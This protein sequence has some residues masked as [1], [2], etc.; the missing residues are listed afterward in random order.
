MIRQLSELNLSKDASSSAAYDERNDCNTS[1]DRGDCE[2]CEDR[3][4]LCSHVLLSQG[5]GESESMAMGN[6]FGVY[7]IRATM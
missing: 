2:D 4:Q 6:S 1:N 7:E 5:D 3:L